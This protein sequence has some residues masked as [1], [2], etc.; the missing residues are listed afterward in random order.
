MLTVSKLSD[1]YYS[2]HI[3][4]N[5]DNDICTPRNILMPH[6]ILAD[7]FDPGNP[8]DLDYLGLFGTR[9]SGLKISRKGFLEMLRDC[10]LVNG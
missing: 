5:D 3:H 2:L 9:Y 7:D 1:T 6:I 10:C 8:S 4:M